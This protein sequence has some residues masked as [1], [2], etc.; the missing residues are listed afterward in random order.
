MRSILIVSARI[1][2]LLAFLVAQGIL[3]DGG[4]LGFLGALLVSAIVWEVLIKLF[5]VRLD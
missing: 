4:T 1:S 3:L 5:H 2:L